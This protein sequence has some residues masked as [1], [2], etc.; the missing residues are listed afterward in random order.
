MANELITHVKE[1]GEVVQSNGNWLTNVQDSKGRIIT[2]RNEAYAR[3][4][5]IGE[6]DIGKSYGTRTSA[7]FEHA[8][9]QFPLV[10]L[11]SQLL[12][13]SLAEKAV[14]ANNNG[15]YFSTQTT[16]EYEQSLEEAE[17]EMKKEPKDWNVFTLPSR[18]KMTMSNTENWNVYEA[19]LNDQAKPYFELNGPI[20]IYPV[21]EKTVDAQDGTLLTQ[22]WF[23]SLDCGSGF[24]GG[25]RSLHYDYDRARWVRK[26][27]ATG[28]QKIFSPEEIKV[29][30]TQREITKNVDILQGVRDGNLPASKLEQVVAFFGKLKQ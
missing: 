12:N 21:D 17:E 1:L 24:N 4:Q 10:R 29:P 30:Y 11:R 23:G 8:K 27:S 2:P 18:S 5:T 20:T 22:L 25:S 15:N 6:K 7:G 19:F 16:K 13:K 9:E 14:A 3:L 28:T 26:K